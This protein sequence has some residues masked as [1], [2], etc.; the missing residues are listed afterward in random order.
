MI[1]T[2]SA[3]SSFMTHKSFL[4]PYACT[5]YMCAHTHMKIRGISSTE[6]GKMSTVSKVNLKLFP[7][8]NIISFGQGHFRDYFCLPSAKHSI[9]HLVSKVLSIYRINQMNEW[10]GTTWINYCWCYGLKHR[11][12]STGKIALHRKKQKSLLTIMSGRKDSDPVSL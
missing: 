7:Y 6:P 12:G 8:Q 9:W 3:F 5:S 2:F 4:G 10:I 11:I 1:F